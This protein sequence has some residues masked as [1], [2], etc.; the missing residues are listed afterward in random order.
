MENGATA[1]VA[2]VFLGAAGALMESP[3]TFVT[4]TDHGKD[5]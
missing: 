4:V 3:V 5:G 1:L 2:L